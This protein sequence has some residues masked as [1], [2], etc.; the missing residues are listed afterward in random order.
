MRAESRGTGQGAIFIVRLPTLIAPNEVEERLHPSA[1]TITPAEPGPLLKDL[2][3]LVVD[4]EF[5]AREVASAILTQAEAEVK[6]A[7]SALEALATM[8]EWRPDVP[9]VDIGMPESRRLRAYTASTRAQS[10]KRR[11]PSL[12]RR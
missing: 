9:V 7:G 4:D 2:R 8:D 5:G 1:N 10:R 12:P 3:V 11:G 6:T